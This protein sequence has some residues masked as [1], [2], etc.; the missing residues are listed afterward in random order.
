M[1]LAHPNVKVFITQGGLQS[2][3]E[4]L[5]RKVPLIGIPFLTDQP[6]NMNKMMQLGLGQ[7]IEKDTLTKESFKKVI[8]EVVENSKYEI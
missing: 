6:K 5:Q 1:V 3:E 2:F 8:I 4:A 7:V